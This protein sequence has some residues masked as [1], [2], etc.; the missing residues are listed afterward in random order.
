MQRLTRCT[1]ALSLLA[2]LGTL[3][4]PRLLAQTSTVR[5][6]SRGTS[7]EQCP[8]PSNAQVE[9]ARP[10]SPVACREGYNWGVGTSFIWVN[11]GCRAE[12]AVTTTGYEQGQ[13]NA[14]ANRN[15]LRACRSEADRRLA[16]YTYDQIS[17]EPDSRQGSVAYVRWWVG[18]TGGLCAVAANG[19]VLQFTTN[20]AGGG[21]GP[22]R[23][24]CESQR[25]GR[26]ECP[27][28]AGA[29]IRLLRQ[30][31][32]DPCRLNDTYGKGAGYIWVAKGCRGE[33]EVVTAGGGGGAG[34]SQVVCASSM[35]TRR[36]CAIPPGAKARLVRQMSAV[37]VPGEPDLGGW[38]GLRVG[39]PRL[40]RRVRGDGHWGMAGRQR[41][42]G[43]DH[44]DRLRVAHGRAGAV[45]GRRRHGH[46]RGEAVQH[47]PVPAQLELRHRVRAHVGKQRLPGG[48]RGGDGGRAAGH[49][50][51]DRTAGAG[52]LRVQGRGAGGVPYPGGGA[53]AARAADR[54][55]A[56]HGEQQLGEWVWHD[57]GDEGVSGG[58]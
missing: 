45:P 18:S 48:V 40:Q 6:E 54:D 7:Q 43:R 17:V 10:L 23:I 26:E 25:Y 20:L 21:G 22:T 8:I 19:R 30:T 35:N 52:G 42:R 29:S 2:F 44:P 13:G 57:L 31:G 55:R 56:V 53:G 16:N 5:C 58:V 36:Q 39:D 4:A 38:P 14:S 11:R 32:Q 9:L 12:F 47:Q 15:Q 51:R 33:F 34:S 49:G 3:S 28:P 37:A 24:A 27:I 50:R 41:R 1:V 46:P